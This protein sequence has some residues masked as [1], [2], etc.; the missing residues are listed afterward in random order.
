M[1]K[2]THP[3]RPETTLIDLKSLLENSFDS[4]WI[5]SYPDYKLIY[6]NKAPTEKLL[7][8][9][10]ESYFDNPAFWLSIIHDEDISIALKQNQDCLENGT[11]ECTY[12]MLRQDGQILWILNRQKLIRNDQGLPTS[13]VGSSLDVTNVQHLLIK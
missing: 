1:S 6:A 13:I 4:S 3:G 8:Y 9:P 12:R 2:I 7:G 10:I 11:A 5:L